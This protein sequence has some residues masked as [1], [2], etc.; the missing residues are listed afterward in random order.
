MDFA[1]IENAW[2]ESPCRLPQA[3]YN[4]ELCSEDVCCG[5]LYM[6]LEGMIICVDCLDSLTGREL[7]VEVLN[8]KITPAG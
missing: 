4:C 6:E 2:L 7:A 1:G 3:I 5:D 8:N